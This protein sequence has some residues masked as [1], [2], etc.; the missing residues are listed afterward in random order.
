MELSTPQAA[1]REEPAAPAAPAA[2]LKAAFFSDSLKE[3]NGTGAYYHD[4][5]G[6]LRPRLAGLE[7]YQ[8]LAD[9]RHPRLAWP[10]PGD[11]TQKLISPH[12]PRIWKACL[13][14]RPDVVVAVTPGPFGLLGLALARRLRRPFISAFHTDFEALARLYWNP[15]SRTVVNAYLRTANRILCRRSGTVLVNNRKLRPQVE[16]LGARVVDVMGTPLHPSFID[17]PAT[18]LPPAFERVCFAGRL[19]AEKNIKTI[20]E[21]AAALPRLRFELAG[22]GPLRAEFEREAARLPNVRFH[23]WLDRARLIELIDRSACLLLPSH[24]ETFGSIAL[25]A[26]ARG[27]PP[28][29]SAAAGILDWE[30]L[31]GGLFVLAPDEPLAGALRRIMDRGPEERQAVADRAREAA[32]RLNDA[33]IAQ[34]T[35]V[36]ARHARPQAE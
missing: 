18:P 7:V 1:A 19:A 22:D 27:R 29:V 11:P 31:A 9:V 13:R 28:L 8:P 30:E 20:L 23:G 5:E 15:V 4:L 34:W 24:F 36:L 17:R 25:E 6:Q 32:L 2:G 16:A 26:M 3:R 12:V 14:F 35:E 10:M 33:T 21:A